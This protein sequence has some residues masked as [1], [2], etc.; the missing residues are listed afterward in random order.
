[1]LADFIRDDHTDGTPVNGFTWQLVMPFQGRDL[2][3][4]FQISVVIDNVRFCNDSLEVCLAP[5]DDGQ[6]GDYNADG[7]VDAADYVL[8]RK[9]FGTTNELAN[10]DI[11]GTIGPPHYNQWRSNFGEGE[12]GAGAAAAA[13]EPTSLPLVLGSIAAV[14]I[15]RRPRK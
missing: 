8:W 7:S 3:H 6:L 2:P 11:G 10:D 4:T 14:A 9:N 5:P 13:P 12:G 15:L 1:V